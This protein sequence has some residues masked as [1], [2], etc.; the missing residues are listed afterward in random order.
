MSTVTPADHDDHPPRHQLDRLAIVRRAGG[1]E[2]HGGDE[3][4]QPD[5]RAEREHADEQR[6]DHAE[7]D[8]LAPVERAAA[9]GIDDLD[10]ALGGK[11]PETA[12]ERV[13]A[14]RHQRVRAEVVEIRRGLEARPSG[15]SP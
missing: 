7:R 6:G 2:Q 11:Q 10:R 3:R 8:P 4:R 13:P 15:S 12:E 14:E 1:D 5:V 9:L